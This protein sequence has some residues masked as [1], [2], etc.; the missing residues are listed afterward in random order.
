[1]GGGPSTRTQ[2]HPIAHNSILFA[3]PP[4]P[5]PPI[6]FFPARHAY[7]ESSTLCTV[8]DQWKCCSLATMSGFVGRLGL[9]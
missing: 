4:L 9:T 3:S 2:S 7:M 6:P 1:M 8:V 5:P